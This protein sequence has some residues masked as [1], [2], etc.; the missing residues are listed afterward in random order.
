LANAAIAA[1]RVGSYPRAVEKSEKS[2]RESSAG[3]FGEL[4]EDPSSVTARPGVSDA[5]GSQYCFP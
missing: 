2:D 4:I 3:P 5:M 1:S